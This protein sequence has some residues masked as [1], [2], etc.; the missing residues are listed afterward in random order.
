MPPALGPG[1]GNAAIRN[2]SL[3]P[4]DSDNKKNAAV[5]HITQFTRQTTAFA[6][7]AR[8]V[9]PAGAAVPS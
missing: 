6:R 9:L 3:T 1:A 5:T 2:S 7:P 4:V 8:R